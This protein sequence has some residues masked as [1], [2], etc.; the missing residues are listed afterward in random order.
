MAEEGTA[1]TAIHRLQAGF[2]DA[3]GWPSLAEWALGSFHTAGLLLAGLL[4]GHSTDGLADLLGGGGDE[5]TLLGAGAYAFLLV[6][7]VFTV[8]LVVRPGDLEPPPDG[9][10]AAHT[11]GRAVLGGSFNAVAFVLPLFGLLI[12]TQIGFDPNQLSSWLLILGIALPFAIAIGSG[13][14]FVFGVLDLCCVLA[15]GGLW[16]DR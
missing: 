5:T 7:T 6:T 13:V 12:G 8:R 10:Q 14:G 11:L 15:V 9:R 3:F 16:P 1:G 4:V 2:R